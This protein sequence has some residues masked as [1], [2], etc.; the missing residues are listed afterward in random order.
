M[1]HFVETRFPYGA[2]LRHYSFTSHGFVFCIMDTW[3]SKDL[4]LQSLHLWQDSSS[5]AATE[6]L[7]SNYHDYGDPHYSDDLRLAFDL[8]QYLS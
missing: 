6:P 4:N 2:Y 3:H 5:L 8:R 1:Y 7:T